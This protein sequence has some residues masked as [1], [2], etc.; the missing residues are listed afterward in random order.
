MPQPLA[1]GKG[2]AVAQGFISKNK[3][4]PQL[5]SGRCCAYFIGFILKQITLTVFATPSA[6]PLLL[7]LDSKFPQLFSE[8][9]A[10]VFVL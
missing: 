10:L 8:P 3:P 7:L 2:F 5:F 6:L 9:A 1:L 4:F